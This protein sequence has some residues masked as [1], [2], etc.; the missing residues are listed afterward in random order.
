MDNP[1]SSSYSAISSYRRLDTI[2]DNSSRSRGVWS[3]EWTSRPVQF[4]MFLNQ[5]SFFLPMPRF[6]SI[7]PS[8]ISQRKSYLSF[9][10]I[11][12]KFA[13]FFFLT[14]LSSS[15]FRF[16]LLNSS[17]FMMRSIQKM[18]SSLGRS[19]ISNVSS[20]LIVL[21]FRVQFSQP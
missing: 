21:T 14:I 7:F 10:F 9:L 13:F 8:I 3:R 1:L 4:R 15:H 20:L 6:S 16:A 17:S 2:M 12:P 18:F 19:H 11:C 5:E